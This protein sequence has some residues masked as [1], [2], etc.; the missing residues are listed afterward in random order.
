MW[1][2]LTDGGKIPA[3][4]DIRLQGIAQGFR[5][6]LKIRKAIDHTIAPQEKLL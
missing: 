1:V 3:V 4:Y 5:S 6:L 2:E